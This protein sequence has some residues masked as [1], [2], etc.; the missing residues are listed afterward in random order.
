MAPVKKRREIKGVIN[1][2]RGILQH[3]AQKDDHLTGLAIN[4]LVTLK[5]MRKMHQPSFYLKPL[6]IKLCH[7]LLYLRRRALT[8]ISQIVKTPIMAVLAEATTTQTARTEAVA[9]VVKI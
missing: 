5:V 1:S 6:G 9:E 2:P 8:A 7:N 4:S 3:Q